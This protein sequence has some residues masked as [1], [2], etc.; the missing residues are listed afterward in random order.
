LSAHSELAKQLFRKGYNCAQAVFAAFCDQTG[1]DIDTALKISSSFGGGMGRLR[2]VCGAVS[3]MLMVVGMEY[4]YTVPSD[5]KAK[6]EHYRLVRHLAKQ[7]EKENGSIICRELLGLSAENDS[8]VPEDRNENYYRKRP[9]LELVEQAA[10]ILDEYISTK[11]E[12]MIKI[13][14]A[15]ENEIVTEHLGH[16]AN[17]NIF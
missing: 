13:A 7:F 11:K 10:K 8:P 9:C 3:G 1:L 6:I 17:F 14:V 5:K 15:S 16:C 12:K 4:G 2:E